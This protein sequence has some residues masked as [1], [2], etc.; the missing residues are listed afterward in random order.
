MEWSFFLST[1]VV[2]LWIGVY[3]G[4][5]LAPVLWFRKQGN[6]MANKL[7]SLL[8]LNTAF[9]ILV[10][11]PQFSD[12]PLISNYAALFGLPFAFLYGPIYYL[13]L[14]AYI[15]KGFSLKGKYLFHFVLPIAALLFAIGIAIALPLDEM[16][17]SERIRNR[18]RI[19]GYVI[20]PIILASTIIFYFFRGIRLV[21]NY[22]KYVKE[23]S[24]Y[25]DP[26]YVRW[27]IS[28]LLVLTLPITSVFFLGPLLGPPSE[29]VMPIPAVGA[30][31]MLIALGIIA[32]VNPTFL[33]GLPEKLK[34]DQ[35]EDLIPQKYQS[36]SLLED[37]KS[38]YH[39]QLLVCIEKE[40][41]YLDQELT[42]TDLSQ[43]LNINTKYLSQII[44]EME[45]K[46]FMDFINF[47]RIE[48][49]K[50]LLPHPAYQHYTILA[51]AQEV[52]F[53]SKSAF[54]NAFKKFTQTTPTAYKASM[55]TA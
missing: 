40:R 30:S 26:N 9:R 29:M 12:Y 10:T 1:V 32:L 6:I 4:L 5:V 33:Q 20:I 17:F 15:E 19:G 18:E 44:N 35:I 49:A 3:Q 22:Y 14:E 48:R 2:L 43:K 54:Y 16:S 53:K 34:V 38:R 50:E 31:F 46:N 28:M 13:Y 55:A 36:S 21:H 52:G 39:R 24:S 23:E 7:L 25:A 41:P 27:L 8:L 45:G 42:L 11:F 47:Y 37:D 51:I